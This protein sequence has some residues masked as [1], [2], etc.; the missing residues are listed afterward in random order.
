[1]KSHF[2]LHNRFQCE[3]MNEEEKKAHTHIAAAAE[4]KIAIAIILRIYI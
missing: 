3:N 4:Q 1:M 2:D